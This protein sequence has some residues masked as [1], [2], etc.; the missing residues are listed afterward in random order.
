MED[1][2]DVRHLPDDLKETGGY[3][4]LKVETLEGTPCRTSFGRGCGLVVRKITE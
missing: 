1:E 4:K 3:W 2:E